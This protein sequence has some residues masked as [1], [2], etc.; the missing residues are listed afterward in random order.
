MA[1]H[2]P[3]VSAEEITPALWFDYVD[4]RLEAGRS[5]STA[6]THLYLLQDFLRFVAEQER[7]VCQRMLRVRSIDSGPRLPRD[8]PQEHIRRLVEQIEADASSTYARI[9]RIGIMD[10]AWFS[11]MLY[12]GLRTGEVRRLHQSDLDLEGR[13]VRIVQSKGLKDRVVYVTQDTTDA[14]HTYLQVL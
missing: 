5:P 10:R 4:D 3:L 12:S 14:L 11:L 7:P 9:R 6:N 1:A 8:V 13:R 2:A